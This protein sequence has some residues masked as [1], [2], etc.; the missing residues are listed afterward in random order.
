MDHWHWTFV[1]NRFYV[2]AFNSKSGEWEETKASVVPNLYNVTAL[3]WKP[4]G[5]CACRP[6]A[7]RPPLDV[8]NPLDDVQTRGQLVV[9]LLLVALQ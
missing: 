2:Y 3:G 1:F 5:R 6:V 7:R 8:S 9:A 4:D